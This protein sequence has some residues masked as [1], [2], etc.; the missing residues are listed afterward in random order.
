MACAWV[1]RSRRGAARPYTRGA[2]TAEVP[3]TVVGDGAVRDTV[4]RVVGWRAAPGTERLPA[5]ARV[6]LLAEWSGTVRGARLGAYLQLHNA[7][8]RRNPLGAGVTG[9]GVPAGGGALRCDNVLETG[10]PPFPTLG[11]RL[12]F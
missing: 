1:A 8:G 4:T 10:I 9:C 7:L 5:L 6:D 12:G 11:L 3:G 2:P